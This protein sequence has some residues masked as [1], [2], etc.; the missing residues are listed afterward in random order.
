LL[1]NYI[2]KKKVR[3]LKTAKTYEGALRVWA[4]SRGREDPDQAVQEIKDKRLDP[5]EVLQE[6]VLHLQKR[7]KVMQKDGTEKEK[8][9]C[10]PKT[11]TTYIGAL[12]GFLVDS[13][14]EIS[15]EKMK[16]KVVLPQAYEIS[17]DRAPT[18]DETRRILIRSNLPTKAAV[19]MLASSGMRLGEL[20]QL[21]VSNIQFGENTSPSRIILKPST[22]KTRKRRMTFISPEATELLKEYLGEKVSDPNM[23]LFPEGSDALYGRIVRAIS[24]TGLREKSDSES[25]RY[26]LHPHCFRKYFFSNCLSAG[27]DRGLVE[28]FM[29]HRFALDSAYLRM[30]DEELAVEYAKAIPKLTFLSGNGNGVAVRNE[31]ERANERIR[32]LEA[33]L[34]ID[35]KDV[36]M[37]REKFDRQM[38]VNVAEN[39]RRRGALTYEEERK[40]IETEK[41]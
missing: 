36:D 34:G 13:D 20:A 38:T 14:V 8:A 28:G 3:S 5:Y 9:G 39:R 16:Q 40:I 29:G 41:T 31:L 17:S 2:D 12:K 27:I 10:A 15:N 25:A 26:E 32:R 37:D 33:A 18:R 11:I 21:K 30:T 7:K 19:V 1:A 4:A 23:I 22:T 35:S 6:F 24:R